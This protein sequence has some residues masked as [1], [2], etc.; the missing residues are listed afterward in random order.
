MASGHSLPQINL[1]VQ[2]G[3]QGVPTDLKAKQER[4]GTADRRTKMDNCVRDKASGLEKTVLND[5]SSYAAL[6]FGTKS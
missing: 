6:L 3:T 5:S 4:K 1:N 2:G